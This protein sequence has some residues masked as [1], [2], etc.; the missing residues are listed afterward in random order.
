MCGDSSVRNAPVEKVRAE[1]DIAQTIREAGSGRL[2]FRR[3][4]CN[5][6]QRISVS[7]GWL[8]WTYSSSTEPLSPFCGMQGQKAQHTMLVPCRMLLSGSR[9][10]INFAA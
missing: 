4:R 6:I 5:K 2:H 9:N 7:K 3:I 1:A 10:R 8:G